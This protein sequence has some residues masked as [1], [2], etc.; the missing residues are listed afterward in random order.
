LGGIDGAGAWTSRHAA[1]D[2]TGHHRTLP[3]PLTAPPWYGRAST[4]GLGWLRYGREITSDSRSQYPV[5][6]PLAM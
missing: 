4:D 6:T 3:I 1:V 5:Q 2:W